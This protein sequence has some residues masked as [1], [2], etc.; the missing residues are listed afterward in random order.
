MRGLW[1]KSRAFIVVCHRYIEAAS[2]RRYCCSVEHT[3]P[4][5]HCC[6]RILKQARVINRPQT[7]RLTQLCLLIHFRTSHTS[8]QPRS[9]TIGLLYSQTLCIQMDPGSCLMDRLYYHFKELS[10]SVK[11]ILLA[12]SSISCHS[13]LKRNIIAICPRWCKFLNTRIKD[14]LRRRQG[15]SCSLY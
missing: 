6:A 4:Q 5:L 15:L 12:I 11:H 13:V 3:R 10:L 14:R 1:K 2:E 9:H 8:S 7:I